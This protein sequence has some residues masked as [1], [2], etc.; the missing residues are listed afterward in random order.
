MRLF[1]FF[2][3]TIS[4]TS[5]FYTSV[6]SNSIS[7]CKEKHGFEKLVNKNF[8]DDKSSCHTDI[9]DRMKKQF[10]VECDCY[11]TQVLSNISCE[12][13]SINIFKNNFDHFFISYYSINYKVKDPPPKNYSS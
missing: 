12:N 5:F 11:L 7:F 2:I 9:K 1:K 3:I 8:H 10:C 6:L 13:L 4:V